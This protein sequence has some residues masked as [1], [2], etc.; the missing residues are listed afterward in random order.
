MSVATPPGAIVCT[1]MPNGCTSLTSTFVKSIEKKWKRS[2]PKKNHSGSQ[3]DFHPE[4][5]CR[6]PNLG[7]SRRGWHQPGTDQLPFRQQGEPVQKRGEGETNNGKGV[8]IRGTEPLNVSAWNFPQEDIDYIPFNVEW[9]HGGSIEKKEM[10]WLNIDH[11]LMG[12]G[13]DNTWGAQVHPEYTIT[14]I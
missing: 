14:G 8:L 6:Y 12:V 7:D 9:R 1:L 13:G 5:I 3:Q 4:G 10:V 2:Q 11:R